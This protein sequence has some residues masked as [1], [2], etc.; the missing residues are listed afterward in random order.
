MSI[1]IY[2]LKNY[3]T[4]RNGKYE[5]ITGKFSGNIEQIKKELQFNKGY[6]Q[7][8]F[9]DTKYI[10]FGD[11]DH[12]P[13]LKIFYQILELI[14]DYLNIELSAI[15]YCGNNKI[16][17]GKIEYSMHFSIPELHGTIQQQRQIMTDIKNKN[18]SRDKI[19]NFPA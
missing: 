8:L 14:A 7:L 3:V 9:N 6:H 2:S 5:P 1:T 4:E 15:K 10:L 18:I 17:N 16:F 13:D 11:I 19:L 12:L